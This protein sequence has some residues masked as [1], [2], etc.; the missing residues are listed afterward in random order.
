MDRLRATRPTTCIYVQVKRNNETYFVL[1]DEYDLVEAVK[2]RILNVLE[3]VGF[4]LERAEE[5]LTTEDIRLC[6]KKRVSK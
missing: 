6:L 1:C 4:Q 5:P 3:Q 2:A